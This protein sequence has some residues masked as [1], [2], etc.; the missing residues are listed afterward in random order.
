MVSLRRHCLQG[1]IK[2]S[3]E[4]NEQG[5]EM[6]LFFLSTPTKLFKELTSS[7]L[8]AS[9]LALS[10]S[11]SYSTS[12]MRYES[13]S[14]FCQNQNKKKGSWLDRVVVLS[15]S[16]RLDTTCGTSMEI[17]LGKR[18]FRLF[19]D[20]VPLLLS[21]GLLPEDICVFQTSKK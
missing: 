6:L 16:S 15:T 13:C 2:C 9:A 10:I 3:D 8:T 20:S 5:I 17:L 7:M 4:F 12:F 19:L 14:S 18:S 11:V 21:S 1:N